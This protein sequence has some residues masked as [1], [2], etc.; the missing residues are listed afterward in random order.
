MI[1][2]LH[3]PSQLPERASQYGRFEGQS[4]CDVQGFSRKV[5]NIIILENIKDISMNKRQ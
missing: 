1:F 5:K 2:N 3:I 4:S